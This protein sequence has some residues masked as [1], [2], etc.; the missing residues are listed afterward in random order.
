MPF[1]ALQS[2]FDAVFAVPGVVAVFDLD[3]DLVELVEDFA[4]GVVVAVFDAADGGEAHAD[5][6]RGL[7]E[8]EV[9]L[10]AG[11][12]YARADGFGLRFAWQSA[13]VSSWSLAGC[14]R[15]VSP[16]MQ[17]RKHGGAQV[18]FEVLQVGMGKDWTSTDGS[19][20][21][22]FYPVS[23]RGQDDGQVY[24]CEWGRKQDSQA[25]RAGDL[26]A[27]R[28]E[29]T[30][31]GLRFK[32]DFDR[33]KELAFHKK[34]EAYQQPAD[35]AKHAQPVGAAP[36]GAIRQGPQISGGPTTPAGQSAKDAAIARMAAQ[37]VAMG[38]Y[39]ALAA[40]GKLPQDFSPHQVSQAAD[41]FEQD[42]R[43]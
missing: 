30:G 35:Y 12:F 4:A 29:N 25:P 5:D 37:K 2:A 14:Y 36:P 8:R 9:S 16:V 38:Y 34:A 24:Q 6:L 19:R 17:V 31:Q 42:A 23:L 10:F 33:T 26:V 3:S 1:E 11:G 40:A 28:V 41:F 20:R 32:M 13:I 18:D 7:F 15:I 27:G 43:R 22:T 21:L 39:Q